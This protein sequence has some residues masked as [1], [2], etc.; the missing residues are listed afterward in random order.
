MFLALIEGIKPKS[1]L[2]KTLEIYPEDRQLQ[3]IIEV[4]TILGTEMFE[5]G[6]S[7][8]VKKRKIEKNDVSTMLA[9][10]LQKD[11]SLEQI[12]ELIS[13]MKKYPEQFGSFQDQIDQMLENLKI[14]ESFLKDVK[15]KWR[16]VSLTC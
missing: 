16:I 4:S 2:T 6:Y 11:L 8:I 15:I 14:V 10:Q 12:G 1:L 9:A 3:C 7:A 5:I 13:I